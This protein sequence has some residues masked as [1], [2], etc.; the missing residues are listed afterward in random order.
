MT[1]SQPE[2]T[3]PA[4]RPP[5]LPAGWYPDHQGVV[6]FWDGSVW[7]QHIAPPPTHAPPSVQQNVYVGGPSRMVTRTR[8]Q[9]SHTFHLIMT[10]LTGGAWGLFVWLPITIYNSMRHDK[11][12]SRIY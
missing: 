11:A 2:W 6:R 12:V 8:K 1:I 9:T 10:L 4:P 7:T 5:T 3:A